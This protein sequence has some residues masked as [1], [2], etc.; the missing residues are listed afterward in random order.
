MTSVEGP[1]LI[2]FNSKLLDKAREKDN[3]RD[4]KDA[5]RARHQVQR[6]ET[7]NCLI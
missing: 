2:E 7:D 5:R 4:T 6:L 3:G 1:Y